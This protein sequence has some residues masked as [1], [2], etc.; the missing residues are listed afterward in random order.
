MLKRVLCCAL[1]V[2]LAVTACPIISSYAEKQK[3]DNL[4]G[5]LQETVDGAEGKIELSYASKEEKAIAISAKN[6]ENT[7][8]NFPYSLFLNNEIAG[9]VTVNALVIFV[10][11]NKESLEKLNQTKNET[12]NL[13]TQIIA[14]NELNK[15]ISKK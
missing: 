6:Y 7:I 1:V 14:A 8:I 4:L 9:E 12:N 15:I 10:Q 3:T 11:L 5:A 13:T 2:M